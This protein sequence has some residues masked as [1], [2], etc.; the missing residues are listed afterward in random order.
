M[1]PLLEYI[2]QYIKMR[3]RKYKDSTVHSTE[4]N[5]PGPG[6]TKPPKN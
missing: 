5:V 3:Y 2:N 4:Y 6:I 1:Y